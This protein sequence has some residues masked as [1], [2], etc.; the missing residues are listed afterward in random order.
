MK[1][2]SFK[3]LLLASV[4]AVGSLSMVPTKYAEGSISDLKDEKKQ[5]E[6]EKKEVES[7]ISEKENK[8]SENQSK[9]EDLV[10]QINSLDKQITDTN[11]KIEEKNAEIE[12]TNKEIEKLKAEI[13]VLKVKIAERDAL[14]KERARSVQ[15]NGGSASYIDVLLGSKSFSD[16]ITRVTAVNT[17]VNADKQILEDQQRD[18]ESLEEKQK[19]VEAKLKQLEEAKANLEALKAELDGKKK[20]KDAL[21]TELRAQ[22]AELEVEKSELEQHAHDLHEMSAEIA[23]QIQAAEEKAAKLAKEAA[24]K[25]AREA[26]AAKKAAASQGSGSGSSSSSGGGGTVSTPSVS[27]GNWTRPAAG[28]VSSEYGARTLNGRADFH[29]GIDIAKSGSVPIVAAA[30][31]VVSKAYYSNSYGNTIFISHY[32]NGTEYTTV[33]AHMSSYQVSNFQTVSKG[34]VIGYMGNTGA[35]YGQHLHFELYIGGWTPS[36]SNAVNPRNY[37]SF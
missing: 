4:L 36:H 6:E 10:A 20:E 32:I 28:Y 13:E 33:Y 37:I 35:S 15:Q 18:K 24:E 25:K 34:Q 30:D 22:E 3:S 23:S 12:E 5:V 8:I 26:E 17:L 14:L 7:Q 16:F 27:S 29:D 21:I 31:G 9:Q 11:T 2:N 19:E 1:V